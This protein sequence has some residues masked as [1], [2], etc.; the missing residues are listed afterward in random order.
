MSS[1]RGF[2]PPDVGADEHIVRRLGWALMRQWGALSPDQQQ[3][4][5]K[6]AVFTDDREEVELLSHKIAAFIAAHHDRGGD[7]H[8]TASE[9]F[10]EAE[11]TQKYPGPL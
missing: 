7:E 9:G 11:L 4:L 10:T 8:P 5:L 6:Q 2:R 1:V 3:I